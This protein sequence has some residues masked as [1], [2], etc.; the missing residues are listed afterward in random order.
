MFG[1]EWLN[2]R[3]LAVALGVSYTTLFKLLKVTNTSGE[4]CPFH[5]MTQHSRKYYSLDEVKKWLKS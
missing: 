2:A 3:Q 4:R 5:R 1:T